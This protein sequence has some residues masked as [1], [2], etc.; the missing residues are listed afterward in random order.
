MFDA[1]SLV[2]L[3]TTD[4]TDSAS[5]LMTCVDARA[6]CPRRLKRIEQRD[7]LLT[8][9]RSPEIFLRSRF[10]LHSSS[11]VVHCN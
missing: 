8:D 1:V 10:F 3:T 9:G 6:D 11:F 2:A 4:G 7:E 5:R